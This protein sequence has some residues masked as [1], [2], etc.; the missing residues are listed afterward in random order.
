MSGEAQG[1]LVFSCGES[2]YGLPSE[3]AAE[4]VNLPVLTRVP[5][6]PAHLV[7]V[8][9]HRGEVV[10]V[11]DLARMLGQTEVHDWKRAVLLR[12]RKGAVALTSSRVQGVV[13]LPGALER[14][15]DVGA[16]ACLR[17]PARTASG[18]V[19]VIDVEAL[20]EHLGRAA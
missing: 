4:V 16:Q 9:A 13:T 14:L 19:V 11:V 10:P 3:L 8:F 7:G 18:E 17:G 5:G 6:A 1:H 20:L 12:H 2:H 15:G